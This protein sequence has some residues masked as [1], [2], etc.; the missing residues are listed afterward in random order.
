LKI[1]LA[2]VHVYGCLRGLIVVWTSSRDSIC[3]SLD[4]RL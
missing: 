1:L 4:F 3:D 2:P